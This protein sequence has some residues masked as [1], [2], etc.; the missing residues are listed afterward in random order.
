[1]GHELKN[2]L[3]RA[4][5]IVGDLPAFSVIGT[6]VLLGG[7]T[8]LFFGPSPPPPS[9]QGTLLIWIF[10]VAFS[11]TGVGMTYRSFLYLSAGH[12]RY[13]LI[14]FYDLALHA[15]FII[16]LYGIIYTYVGIVSER[17]RISDSWD[18]LYFSIVTWTTVGYGD[19]VPSPI[20][21]M[22]A[23]SEALYGYIFMGLYISLIFHAIS[24]SRQM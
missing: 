8:L 6:V 19:F 2:L 3:L 1:M 21:R 4:V 12:L 23:A 20:G 24:K 22:F 17:E 11:I 5:Q 15:T 7:I 10:I 13:Y 14:A 16:V 18:C 9:W